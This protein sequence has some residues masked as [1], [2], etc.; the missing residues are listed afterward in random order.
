MQLIIIET[1]SCVLILVFKIEQTL[2]TLLTVTP[3]SLNLVLLAKHDRQRFALPKGR[4]LM[5]V[6]ARAKAKLKI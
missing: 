5:L 2:S 3:S 6:P 1:D 4:E